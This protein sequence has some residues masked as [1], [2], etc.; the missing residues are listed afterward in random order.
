MRKERTIA[1][2]EKGSFLDLGCYSWEVYDTGF[3]DGLHGGGA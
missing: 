1:T 3:S 2:S